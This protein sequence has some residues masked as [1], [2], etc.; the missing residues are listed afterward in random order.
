MKTTKEIAQMFADGTIINAIYESKDRP[1]YIAELHMRLSG[2]FAKLAD[3]LKDI[4]VVKSA[5]YKEYLIEAKSVAK[6]DRLWIT[7]NTGCLEKPLK[8]EM[9]AL[10]ALLKSLTSLHFINRDEAKNQY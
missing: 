8:L 3:E 7:D 2:R 1:K 6:V 9:Q 10:E 5:F 4:E